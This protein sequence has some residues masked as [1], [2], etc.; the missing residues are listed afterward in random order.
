[1]ARPLLFLEVMTSR[2]QRQHRRVPLARSAQIELRTQPQWNLGGSGPQR[3]TVPVEV[4]DISQGG[5]SIFVTT[6]IDRGVNVTVKL[7]VG[8][9]T[10]S[11]P[12]VVVWNKTTGGTAMTAGVR[13]HVAVLDALTRK[14]YEN[15]V[16]EIERSVKAPR[17]IVP[18]AP[19]EPK[20]PAPTNTLFNK[21]FN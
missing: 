10:I 2:N 1:M 14:A 20:R 12:A 5:M 18:P 16:L 13:V 3:R 4:R 9:R 7:Q 6:T 19:A 8:Q 17:A 21:L 11:I 15:F